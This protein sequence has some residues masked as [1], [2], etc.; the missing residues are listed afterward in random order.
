M[1][2]P[3]CIEKGLSAIAER[4]KNG[5]VAQDGKDMPGIAPR[6]APA[7]LACLQKDACHA[8]FRQMKSQ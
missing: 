5:F 6:S 8:R 7:R 1:M 4:F 3:E 2:F